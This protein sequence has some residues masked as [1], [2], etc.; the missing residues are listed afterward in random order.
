[1]A[2]GT[3][4]ND[5]E[6]TI[7]D[8]LSDMSTMA[9]LGVISISWYVDACSLFRP[10]ASATTSTAHRGVGHRFTKDSSPVGPLY[11]KLTHTPRERFLAI[12]N[13]SNTHTSFGA[14]SPVHAR[15][16]RADRVC[17]CVCAHCTHTLT[18]RG[19]QV[20]A[21]GAVHASHNRER[22]ALCMVGHKREGVGDE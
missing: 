2:S 10:M 19:C 17:V 15:A 12:P 22:D 20:R 21:N 4:L 13:N 5:K 9:S 3:T 1:M 16:R 7:R 8:S 18:D 6:G 11:L 14:W